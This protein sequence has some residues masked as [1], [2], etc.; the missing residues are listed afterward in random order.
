[1]SETS[2]LSSPDCVKILDPDG[3]VLFF[4]E[5]GLRLMEIDEFQE[6]SNVPWVDL[7]PESERPLL[8]SAL[9]QARTSGTASFQAKCP[10]AKGIWRHWDVTVATLPGATSQF[11]VVSRDITEMIALR[12]A[13]DEELTRLTRISQSNADILWDID[14]AAGKVWWGEGLYRSL[15]Y[16]RFEVE[17]GVSWRDALIHPSDLHHVAES[18]K[19]VMEDGSTTW[20][21]EYRVRDANGAYRAVWDRGAIHRDL[22]GKPVRIFGVM[23]D[24]TERAAR[25]E[26]QKAVAD[27]LGHR[28]NNLLAV[29]SGLFENSVRS[30][31]DRQS[32]VET[33]RGRIV[34][35]ASANMAVLRSERSVVSLADLVSVQ[36][37][38]Y[39]GAGR[40]RLDGS[41][42]LLPEW[43][44]QPF[45]LAIN[46]LATNAV[47]Y[48]ALSNQT[49]HI[50]LTW[51]QV[52]HRNDRRVRIDW[53]EH[54]GPRVSTPTRTGTGSKLI[55]R[56]IRGAEVE[57]RFLP[58]GFSCTIN[59]PME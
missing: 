46:E 39:I 5:A 59:A 9:E 42:V 3:H 57:R 35:I 16:D 24:I 10:T 54:G 51:T 29:V 55:E 30:S 25:Y 2:C 21:A 48:G 49:G 52:N 56:G 31:N 40:V 15:G 11:V 13:Q 23:Q 34:A 19:A 38:P 1:M 22:A 36:L 58:E 6:I 37:A 44:A 47:K 7:W 50:N 17:E 26:T 20:E 45:A 4:N 12:E 18:L 28:V 43:L 53:N 41:L 14:V 33:F 32:L 27:E 8:T